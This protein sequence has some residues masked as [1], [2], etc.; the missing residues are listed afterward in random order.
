MYN[1]LSLLKHHDTIKILDEVGN[2]YTPSVGNVDVTI[3]W[4][5]FDTGSLRIVFNEGGDVW[6]N[7]LDNIS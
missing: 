6:T 5:T 1:A 3:D 7:S 2:E 4:N